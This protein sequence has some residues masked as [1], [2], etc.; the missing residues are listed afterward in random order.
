M[1]PQ[2]VSEI[3]RLRAG[4]LDARRIEPHIQRVQAELGREI[5]AHLLERL[6][7]GAPT[8]PTRAFLASVAA[9]AI[10]AAVFTALDRW[11]AGADHDLDELSRLTALALGV[12]R[13]RPRLASAPDLGHA[14]R[15][16]IVDMISAR[17][18]RCADR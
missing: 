15:D 5:E 13:P 7:R 9:Q 16:V 2:V 11:M 1:I 10:A 6:R 14:M 12:A 4:E 17:V 3:A 18:T 8:S